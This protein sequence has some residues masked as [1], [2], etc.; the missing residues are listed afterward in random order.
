MKH[1]PAGAAKKEGERER[2]KMGGGG[3]IAEVRGCRSMRMG[4]CD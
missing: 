3:V 1:T 4:G 2:E